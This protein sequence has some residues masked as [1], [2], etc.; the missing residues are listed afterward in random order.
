MAVEELPH[1]FLTVPLID[2]KTKAQKLQECS[3]S[4]IH[5]QIWMMIIIM[6]KSQN[7]KIR[8]CRFLVGKIAS[9]FQSFTHHFTFAGRSKQ[10]V[11]RYVPSITHIVLQ[12]ICILDGF[13]GHSHY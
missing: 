6:L 11:G 9:G 13:Y 8:Q 7:Q 12:N 1:S 2:D 4:I 5:C 3:V 10:E